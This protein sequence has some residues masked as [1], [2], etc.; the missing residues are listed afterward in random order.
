MRLDRRSGEHAHRA[1]ARWR[2]DNRSCSAN[3]ATIE[4]GDDAGGR[5]PLQHQA[6]RSTSRQRAGTRPGRGRGRSQTSTR[7]SIR[8]ARRPASSRAARTIIVRG[9]VESMRDSR[10]P[11]RVRADLRRRAGLPADGDQLPELARPAHHPDG[12]A[13]RAG[14][15]RVDAVRHA[16]RRSACRR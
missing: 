12:A 5:Q 13:R 3:L 9:Q 11:A 16:A 6:G 7:S 4:R 14:G 1:G 15:H 10:S 8:E 2:S